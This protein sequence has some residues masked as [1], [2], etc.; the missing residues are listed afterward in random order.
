MESIRL[1]F[2]LGISKLIEILSVVIGVVISVW[3]AADAHK[4][5][6]EARKIESAKPFLELGQRLYMEALKNGRDLGESSRPSH[7]T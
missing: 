6:A 7:C 5:S 3:K 4:S 1:A 2:Q